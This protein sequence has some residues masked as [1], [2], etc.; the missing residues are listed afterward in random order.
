MGSHIK[1]HNF[2]LDNQ[3]NIL[4][5]VNKPSYLTEAW[6]PEADELLDDKGVGLSVNDRFGF[7]DGNGSV[8]VW[9]C[10]EMS[11]FAPLGESLW[12]V[13]LYFKDDSLDT[14]WLDALG[15][16][17]GTCLGF[18]VGWGK[19]IFV[20]NISINHL[21]KTDDKWGMTTNIPYWKCITLTWY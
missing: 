2:A 1:L 11:L 13:W 20:N 5:L 19:N 3:L 6:L 9:Y 14:V 15:G 10:W 4:T 18:P 8:C 16:G 17:A 12:S 7:E 21:L